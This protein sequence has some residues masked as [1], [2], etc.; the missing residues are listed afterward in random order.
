MT[1]GYF[2]ISHT[3]SLVT[4]RASPTFPITC[5]DSSLT[6]SS[7][8]GTVSS[9]CNTEEE[10]VHLKTS[11]IKDPSLAI[12]E[13]LVSSFV[14]MRTSILCVKVRMRQNVNNERNDR[15]LVII[16]GTYM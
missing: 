9:N 1:H 14:S 5:L 6:H 12:P 4:D 16:T 13:S 8:S 2:V 3:D 11:N 10:F 7:D 15:H